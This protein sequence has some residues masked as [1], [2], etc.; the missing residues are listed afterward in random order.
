M[1][2]RRRAIVLVSST[3]L[4]AT[5]GCAGLDGDDDPEHRED[6]P[7]LVDFS[8]HIEGP[9]GEEMIF[10]PA[11]VASVGEVDE[12]DIGPHVPV[13][14]TDEAVEDAIETYENIGGDE[15]G[16]DIQLTVTIEGDVA[17]YETYDIS[18]GLA[19]AID[20]GDWDGEFLIHTDSEGDARTLRIGLEGGE[21]E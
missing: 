3:A 12:D 20:E 5:A 6:A 18:P 21:P 15:T 4:L 9:N 13:Q 14:F 1:V 11:D 8:I 2:P 19:S 10:E 7:P 17:R 16:E